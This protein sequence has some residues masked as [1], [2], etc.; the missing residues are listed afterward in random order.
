[1]EGESDGATPSVV[2]RLHLI[3]PKATVALLQQQMA[4]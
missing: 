3:G 4:S 2:G 1:V